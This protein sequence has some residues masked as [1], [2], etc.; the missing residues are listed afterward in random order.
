MQFIAEISVLDNRNHTGC[1]TRVPRARVSKLKEK[2]S[3]VL[4]PGQNIQKSALSSIF[5]LPVC[6]RH[7]FARRRRSSL[8]FVGQNR[9]MHTVACAQAVLDPSVPENQ[10]RQEER[11]PFFHL[12]RFLKVNISPRDAPVTLYLASSRAITTKPRPK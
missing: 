4:D 6:S 11:Q 3:S 12:N 8:L 10:Q 1:S 2:L 5:T 9:P 7:S